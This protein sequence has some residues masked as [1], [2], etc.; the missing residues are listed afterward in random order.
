[1]L[2]RTGTLPHSSATFLTCLVQA[3]RGEGCQQLSGY[4]FGLVMRHHGY[5]IGS[6]SVDTVLFMGLRAA[7]TY[8]EAAGQDESVVTTQPI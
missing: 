7:G 2:A 1:M 5:W 4:L 8:M 3:R 6:E